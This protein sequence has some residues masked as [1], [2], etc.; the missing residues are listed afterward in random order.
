MKVKVKATEMITEIYVPRTALASFMEDA[1]VTLREQQAN[2]IYGTVRLIE[3]DEESFLCW[4]RQS[5]ACV[6]FNLHVT[7]DKRG[8]ERAAVS[9]RSLIDL[10]LRYGGSYYLTYHRFATRTQVE[11]CYPQMNEF[12]RLKRE[13]D[14]QE[15]FQSDWYRHY[16]ATF[17]H[18]AS[19]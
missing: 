1:R 18:P 16:K 10:G 19:V 5:Y 4:A 6:I 2:I 3:R 7:H 11:A 8:V 9:F 14:P 13:Y 15:V 17:G 12:L